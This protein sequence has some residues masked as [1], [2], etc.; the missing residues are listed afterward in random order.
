MRS[1]FCANCGARG[2]APEWTRVDSEPEYL[3]H[4]HAG[5]DLILSDYELPQFSG[6]RALELLQASGLEIPA[7]LISGTIGEDTAVAAMKQGAV[8]YLLKDRLTRLGPAV[9]HALEQSKLRQ[10]RK[11]AEHELRESEERFRQVMHNIEEVFWMTNLEMTEVLFVSAAYEKIWG[12]TCASLYASPRQWAEA[13]HPDDLERVHHAISKNLV[14][15]TYHEEFRI[16]RPDGSIRWIDDRAFPVRNE[17]GV[18]F[19][20]AGVAQDIT[21]RRDAEAALRLFRAQ[22]DQSADSFE[23]VDPVTGRFLDVSGQ[24]LVESGFTREE[25]LSQRVFDIDPFITEAAWPQVAEGVRLNG[26]HIGEGSR[27]RKDGTEFFIELKA[28]WVQLD[29]GYIVAVIRDITARKRAEQYVREQAAMLE[30]AHDA[31]MVRGFEDQLISFWNRGA[32]NL[33]GWTSAEALGRDIGEL[34]CVD[35]E[36]PYMIRD[37]LLKSE[38]WRGVTHHRTRNG[39]QLTVNTRATLVRDDSGTPQVSPLDQYRCHRAKRSRGALPPDPAY[40]KYWSLGGR[41]RP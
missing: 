15:H 10:E 28:K 35:P 25:F 26:L 19:R 37:A 29:G 24:G 31:I 14:E 12:R 18:I 3:A 34:I 33:Y 17:A 6:I 5:L 30:L 8:D 38:E 21:E 1:W 39:K 23:V 2:F 4:L 13:I 11:R 7:I 27:R 16:V 9:E 36:G 20:L 22:V 41:H 32:E 40:G